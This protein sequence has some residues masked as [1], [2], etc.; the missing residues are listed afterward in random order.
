MKRRTLDRRQLAREKQ[1]F[2]Y[3]SALDRGDFETIAAILRDAEH[4]AALEQMIAE[5]NLEAA[6]EAVLSPV[7]HPASTNHHREDKRMTALTIPYPRQPAAPAR[8]WSIQLV[9]LVALAA[10]LVA[11]VPLVALR[12]GPAPSENPSALAQ[13]GATSTPMPTLV[14]TPTPST[15]AGTVLAQPGMPGCTLLLQ[16]SDVLTS[17]PFGEGQG[18]PLVNL[19]PPDGV[20]AV[21][22][23]MRSRGDSQTYAYRVNA[24]IGGLGFQ[25]WISSPQ[26]IEVPGC[27]MTSQGEALMLSPL[28][29]TMIPGE[30][31]V[32]E[33]PTAGLPPA[34]CQVVN[35]GAEPVQIVPVPGVEMS[36]GV[37]QPGMLADVVA[38]QPG[39]GGDWYLITVLPPSVVSGGIV[40]TGWVP[41]AAV[42]TL[43]DCVVF[44]AVPMDP[45][46]VPTAIAP[47]EMLPLPPVAPLARECA[48]ARTAEETPLL[49]QPAA[50]SPVVATLPANA[51]VYLV[52]V[53]VRVSLPEGQPTIWYQVE[54]QLGE[55]PLI[56]WTQAALIF[57]ATQCMAA[58]EAGGT[59]LLIVTATPIGG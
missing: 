34:I 14:P 3:L 4:D 47:V 41:V 45:S 12:L 46:V 24:Q 7:L 23:E 43:T 36:A 33:P 6:R 50:G 42:T 1:L 55:R 20:M 32:G 37:L 58:V 17:E 44:P 25:G 11:F 8:R 39:Q 48:T 30:V 53:E 59:P 19:V 54:A 52:V 27:V 16:P 9:A 51:P 13:G 28:V 56:G 18:I 26:A 31:I 40:L 35:G 10:A 2:R 21:V 22:V 15:A 57:D 38:I 49:G 29:P 5:V